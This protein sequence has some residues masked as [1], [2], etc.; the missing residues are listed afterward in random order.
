VTET[1]RITNNWP[2]TPEEYRQRTDQLNVAD[3]LTE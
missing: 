1:G 2:G 3:Y